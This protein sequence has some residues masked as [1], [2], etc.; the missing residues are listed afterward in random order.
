MLQ[1]VGMRVLSVLIGYV[2]GMFQTAYFYG[3][4][5]GIDIREHGSGNAGTTNTLR[6]LGKRAGLIVLL[7][8]ICKTILAIMLV[9]VLFVYGRNPELRL[10]LTMYTGAGAVLG[11]DCPIY[12]KGRGGKGIAVTAGLVIAFDY[13]FLLMGI[14]TFFLPFGLTGYVSLGS[15][16]FYLIFVVQMIICGQCNLAGMEVLKQSQKI[17]MY[18]IAVL[19]MAVAYYKHRANIVRLIKGEERKTHILKKK[20]ES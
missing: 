20:E 18:V 13:H 19:L 7:G 15:L 14:L 9:N 17:E 4:A 10:L 3:K 12:L 6:V 16:V 1:D 11:H 2:F 5:H 8:D